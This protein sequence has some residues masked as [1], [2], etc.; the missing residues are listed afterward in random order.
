MHDG[1]GIGPDNL[2]SRI[3][4]LADHVQLDVK[5]GG[6]GTWAFRPMSA[7]DPENTIWTTHHRTKEIFALTVKYPDVVQNYF[8]RKILLLI[9][10]WT[11][12]ALN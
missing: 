4:R 12:L 9:N 2:H 5:T 3:C 7:L 10:Q 8:N 6:V 11:D 1:M